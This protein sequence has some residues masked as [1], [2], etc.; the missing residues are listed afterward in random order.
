MHVASLSFVKSNKTDE[1]ND[2]DDDGDD[3][4]LP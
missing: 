4:G 2:N 3:K 1:G